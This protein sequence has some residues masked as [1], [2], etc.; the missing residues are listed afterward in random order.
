MSPHD[1]QKREFFCRQDN[2]RL[3]ALPVGRFRRNL[4]RTRESVSASILSEPNFEIFG[5][6]GRLPPKPLKMEFCE[7]PQ[8]RTATGQG[9]CCRSTAFVQTVR[10]HPYGCPPLGRFFTR[11]NRFRA[12][13]PR[14][15]PNFVRH[16]N[17]NT[18]VKSVKSWFSIA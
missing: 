7:Y 2:A 3:E 8:L 4:V 6:R 17:E 13:G 9:I 12:R 10:E 11:V 1:D 14:I 18:L 16:F 5:F 15:C